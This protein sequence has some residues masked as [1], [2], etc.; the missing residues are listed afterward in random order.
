MNWS[1]WLQL[2][3]TIL[4]GIGLYLT[5]RKGN[6]DLIRTFAERLSKLEALVSADAQRADAFERRVER[7]LD[8]IDK[9]VTELERVRK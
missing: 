7:Q 8:H 9:R 5:N 4:V 1:V 6:D 3:S 2:A